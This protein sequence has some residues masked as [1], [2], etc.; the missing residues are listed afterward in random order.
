MKIMPPFAEDMEGV[1]YHIS[2]DGVT[3][4]IRASKEESKEADK[5]LAEVKKILMIK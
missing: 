1:T 4:N 2:V 3:V 5:I